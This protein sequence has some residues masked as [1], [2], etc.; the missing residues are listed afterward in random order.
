MALSFPRTGGLFTDD[1][2][3]PFFGPLGFPDVTRDFSRALA[4]SE[5]SQQQL[6]LATRGMPVDV[7]EKEDAFEVKADIP[8]VKKEDIKVTVDKDVLRINV[9]T[10]QEQKEEKEEEGR[11]WHRYERSSQFVGRALR[12]PEGA[13]MDAIR[14]RYDNGV[15]TLDV[16]KKETKK[17][18]AKRITVA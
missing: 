13:N 12:M 14:A 5:G 4:P 18:E 8:G 15:L 9:E 6:A 2:F 7:V 11:K 17:E 10:S 1:F 16:P 3:S